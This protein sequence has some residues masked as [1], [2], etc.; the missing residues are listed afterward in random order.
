MLEKS[1]KKRWS[2]SNSGYEGQVS[3][4]LM[5]DKLQLSTTF[6]N[7]EGGFSRSGEIQ[8][9]ATANETMSK[10]LSRGGSSFSLLLFFSPITVRPL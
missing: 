9:Q 1:N 2:Q 4:Y 3:C 7:R 6:L 8:R 5:Y 10:F